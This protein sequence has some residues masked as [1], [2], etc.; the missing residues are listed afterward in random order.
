M[1]KEVSKLVL[2]CMSFDFVAQ[3][4]LYKEGSV[5]RNVGSRECKPAKLH[6]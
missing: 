4:A 5:A 1:V 6:R 3:A 2:S